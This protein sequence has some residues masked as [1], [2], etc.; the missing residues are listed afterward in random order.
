MSFGHS[1]QICSVTHVRLLFE[2]V[3]IQVAQLSSTMIV[4]ASPS[5][6]FPEVLSDPFERRFTWEI[7]DK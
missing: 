5:W 1:Y 7:P 2:F 3:D 4:V 6:G